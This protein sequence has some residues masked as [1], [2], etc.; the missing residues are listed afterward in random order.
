MN[1]VLTFKSWGFYRYL[2]YPQL[3]KVRTSQAYNRIDKNNII[4]N[5]QT[6]NITIT[7]KRKGNAIRA[8]K[9]DIRQMKIRMR[10]CI[11]GNRISAVYFR[12]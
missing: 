3:N 8:V 9:Q 5:I 10:R 11:T 1:F 2:L 7:T 12:A 6:I 4:N